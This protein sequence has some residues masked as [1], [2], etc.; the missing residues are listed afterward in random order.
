MFG[1][2]RRP[3]PTGASPVIRERNA[4]AALLTV[5][6]TGMLNGAGAAVER[7]AWRRGIVFK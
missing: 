2:G 7:L 4:A 3:D 5:Y 6:L 1:W